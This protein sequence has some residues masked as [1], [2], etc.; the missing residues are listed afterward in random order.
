ML[1]WKWKDFMVK[2]TV[3]GY[4]EMKKHEQLWSFILRTVF[5]FVIFVILFYLYS[6]LGQGQGEFIYNEF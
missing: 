3:E 4:I 1:L 2:W 5:Y 6:Y